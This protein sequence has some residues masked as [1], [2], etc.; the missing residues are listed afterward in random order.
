[1]LSPRQVVIEKV[2]QATSQNADLTS[3]LGPTLT[4]EEQRTVMAALS[5][6][7]A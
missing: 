6:K 4:A 5:A 1:L 7:Q 3:R 2:L